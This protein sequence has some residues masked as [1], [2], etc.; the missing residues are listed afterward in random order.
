MMIL[1]VEKLIKLEIKK[2]SKKENYHNF[3]TG[4]DEV[5]EYFHK[6]AISQHENLQTVLY[7][8]KSNNEIVAFFTL[9]NDKITFEDIGNK[10][11][12]RSFVTEHF[13]N[14]SGF[15]YFSA[16]KI[17]YIGVKKEYHNFG[18]GTYLMNYIKMMIK[19]K[20]LGGGRFLTV[21]SYKHV[22]NFYK[23]NGFNFISNSDE[24]YDTRLMYFD[25]KSM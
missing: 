24:G 4:F 13:P 11:C 16:I 18:I 7:L 8:V 17:G 25:L 22:F 20:M 23:K 14:G 3:K 1:H 21:D 12:W 9:S 5:D 15:I 10:K 2:P 19:K 6:E